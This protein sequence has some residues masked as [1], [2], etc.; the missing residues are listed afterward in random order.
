[1]SR[2]IACLAVL[3]AIALVVVGLVGRRAIARAFAPLLLAGILAPALVG[4]FVALRRPGNVVAWILLLGALSVVGG[5]ARRASIA[6]L[7]GDT[8]LGPVGGDGRRAV[9]GAVPVAA[10]AGVRVPG[11]RAALAALA[12]GRVGGGVDRRRDRASC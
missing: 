4:L 3:A 8:T 11:R 12:A 10:G 7:E 6:E 5:D 1:M 2:V 9:A